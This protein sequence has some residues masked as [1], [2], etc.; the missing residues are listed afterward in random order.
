[1]TIVAKHWVG[2]RCKNMSNEK[3]TGWLGYIGHYTTHLYKDYN[4]P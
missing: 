3:N 1:M 2:D 4:K